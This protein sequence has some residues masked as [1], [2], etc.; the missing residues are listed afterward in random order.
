[1]KQR[2]FVLEFVN[3]RAE[4][5]AVCRLSP[6]RPGKASY[7]VD[8]SLQSEHGIPAEVGSAFIRTW[9]DWWTQPSPAH[10]MERPLPAGWRA[11]WM[12]PA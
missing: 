10:G 1:M 11:S 12:T 3:D 2:N 8:V 5:K 4:V 9:T 7:S 6:P